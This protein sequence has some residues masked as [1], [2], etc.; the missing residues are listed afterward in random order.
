MDLSPELRLMVYQLLLRS[1]KPFELWSGMWEPR[2]AIFSGIWKSRNATWSHFARYK[3]VLHVL[4]LSKEIRNEATS[5]F[6]GENEFRMSAL[7]SF[8]IC[9][10]FFL[11]IGDFNVRFLRKLTLDTSLGSERVYNAFPKYQNKAIK[12][13]AD[14]GMSVRYPDNM[15]YPVGMDAVTG[16][17]RTF[18]RLANDGGV[19]LKELQLLWPCGTWYGSYE[20]FEERLRYVNRL[21]E[22]IEDLRISLILYHGNCSTEE[23]KQ[24]Y[25]HSD[26]WRARWNRRKSMKDNNWLLGAALDMG[27]PLREC[28]GLDDEHGRYTVLDAGAIKDDTVT[29]WFDSYLDSDSDSDSDYDDDDY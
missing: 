12:L 3:H 11:T 5:V 13:M 6:W 9:D 23:N 22:S 28:Y 17:L 10:T 2:D 4:R 15:R 19:D 20:N 21:K 26:D 8:I 27:W 24:H 14:R 18:H 7:N 25:G 16:V 1:D 29:S